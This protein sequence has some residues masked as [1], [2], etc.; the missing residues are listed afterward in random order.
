MTFR[1]V[2]A[3]VPQ[4]RP[5]PGAV[6]LPVLVDRDSG[7]VVV[8]HGKPFAILSFRIRDGLIHEINGIAAPERVARMAGPVV[9][10]DPV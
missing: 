8:V 6:L 10:K 5:V 9:T 2:D 1:G 4:A 7:V 3:V